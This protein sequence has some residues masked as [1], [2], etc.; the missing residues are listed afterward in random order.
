VPSI[1]IRVCVL[2]ALAGLA[3]AQSYPSKPIR[4][5]AADSPKEFSPAPRGPV[6]V[7]RINH[8]VERTR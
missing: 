2:S 5:L 1:G 3:K 7:Q 8:M 4:I 6:G